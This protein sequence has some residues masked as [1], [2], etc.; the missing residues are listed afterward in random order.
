[1]RSRSPSKRSKSTRAGGSLVSSP[2]TCARYVDIV[3]GMACVKNSA[4]DPTMSL[5]KA[6]MEPI[7][8]GATSGMRF[9][10]IIIATRDRD[11]DRC[12]EHGGG[13]P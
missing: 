12:H 10:M 3:L 1:M 9:G 7:L 5:G 11:R 8:S 13:S 4:P 2:S 6:T